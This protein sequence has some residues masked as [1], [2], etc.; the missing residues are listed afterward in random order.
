MIN[1]FNR[2]LTDDD[3]NEVKLAAIKSLPEFIGDVPAN[4][5]STF[6]YFDSQNK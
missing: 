2:L 5:L 3:E 6:A 4:D 1:I